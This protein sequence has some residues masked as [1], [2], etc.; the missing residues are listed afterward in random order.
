[1]IN[2]RKPTIFALLYLSGSKIPRNLKIIQKLAKS[3]KREIRKYQKEKLKKL[4][5]HAYKNVPYYH[6]VLAESG[7]IT[8]SGK[9]NLKK[10]PNIPILT[11]EIIRREGKNLYSHDCKRRGYYKNSSGGSTG[12]PVEFLQ[13]RNYSDWNIANKLFYKISAG[14]KIGEPEL[15]LWGSERDLLEGKENW[16]IR[17][18]N[19]LYNRHDFNSFSINDERMGSLVNNWN[20]IKPQWVESYVQSIYEFSQFLQERKFEVIAPRGILVSAGMLYPKMRKKIERVFGVKVYNRYG[21]REV[22]DMACSC[23]ESDELHLSPWNHY[24]EVLKTSREGNG[25]VCVTTLNNYSMPLIRYQIG[26]VVILKKDSR[27]D[28]GLNT[29]M[30]TKVVGRSVEMLLTTKGDKIDGEFFTHLFYFQPWVKKFIVEQKSLKRLE[31]RYEENSE[32]AAKKS[33][34]K[35]LEKTIK[36]VMGRSCSVIWTKVARIKPLKSG[37][38]LYTVSKINHAKK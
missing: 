27:C 23:G 3:S 24:F 2:W 11:K 8:K 26:D 10:F 29:S 30:I 19:W 32:V 22:G 20:Q 35:E 7:V 14:Y 18:R 31:I 16:K 1:M 36:K 38:H 25:S 6:R 13:D 34:L 17:V 12:E 37:K 21:S 15:R 9:I 5:S 33:D 4:L 28:C